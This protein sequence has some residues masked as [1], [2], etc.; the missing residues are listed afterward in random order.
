MLPLDVRA[1]TM[2]ERPLGTMADPSSRIL[3][4]HVVWQKG[5]RHVSVCFHA[6]WSPKA[7]TRNPNAAEKTTTL[8][9]LGT[10]EALCLWTYKAIKILS[11]L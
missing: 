4:F 2:I 6:F 11:F 7:E 5:T 10:S 3:E 9:N 1:A 8:V